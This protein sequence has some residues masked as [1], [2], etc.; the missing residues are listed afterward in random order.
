MHISKLTGTVALLAVGMAFSS[1][2]FANTCGQ[3]LAPSSTAL[4]SPT[5]AGL[6]TS[7]LQHF[8]DNRLKDG[9]GVRHTCKGQGINLR[10]ETTHF[11]LEDV[12]VV[13][14]LN[15]SIYVTAWEDSQR[16]LKSAVID[17]APAD[18]WQEQSKDAISS[19]ITVRRGNYSVNGT[20][21]GLGDDYFYFRPKTNTP[22]D[23]Q[24]PEEYEFTDKPAANGIGIP[25]GTDL[26]T[27]FPLRRASHLTDIATEL[28]VQ[29]NKVALT[30]TT[31]INGE[32]A[33]WVEWHLKR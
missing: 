3:R 23:P 19:H 18:H 28:S 15:G 1:T 21:A 24:N 2:A 20:L 31:Y 9:T 14:S 12:N 7:L 16:K 22:G 32:M 4:S 29:G 27:D 6:A 17:L 8:D 33:E 25:V 30:Q 11:D 10:I 5:T 26:F 13:E